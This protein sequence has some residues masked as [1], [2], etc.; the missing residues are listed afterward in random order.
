MGIVSAWDAF[1]GL[2]MSSVN[3]KYDCQK[4]TGIIF[5]GIQLAICRLKALGKL[6]GR[7]S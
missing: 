5:H 6:Y 1:I 7:S 4:M 2:W 3:R